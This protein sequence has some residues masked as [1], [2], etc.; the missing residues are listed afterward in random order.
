MVR[1]LPVGGAVFLA[2]LAEGKPL[3]AA[4]ASTLA[5]SPSFQLAANIAGLLQAGAFAAVCPGG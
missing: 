3:G 2:R 4:A 1:R 5:E